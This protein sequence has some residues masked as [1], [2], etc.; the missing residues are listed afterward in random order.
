[1][2]RPGPSRTHKAAPAQAIP[3]AAGPFVADIL[4]RMVWLAAGLFALA[5]IMGPLFAPASA[6][7]DARSDG[8]III[9]DINANIVR[10]DHGYDALQCRSSEDGRQEEL[11]ALASARLGKSDLVHAG[12]RFWDEQSGMARVTVEF[13]DD[14]ETEDRR[15]RTAIGEVAMESCEA[16]LISI[17]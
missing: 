14:T 1:M 12:T 4:R 7:D 10:A 11:F 17:T 15:L 8:P 6:S 13:W 5:L 9:P 3:L 16:K 2:E